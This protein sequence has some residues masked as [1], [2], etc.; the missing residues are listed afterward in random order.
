VAGPVGDIN[1]DGMADVLI[2]D[3]YYRV[4]SYAVGGGWLIMG[5]KW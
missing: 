2:T 4:G 3:Q 5:R 1:G